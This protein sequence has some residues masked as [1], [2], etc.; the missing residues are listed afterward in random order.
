MTEPRRLRACLRQLAGRRVPGGC[1]DCDAY[2]VMTEDSG[3]FVLTVH[4]DDT[5]PTYR[6]SVR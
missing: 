6:G 1:G 5:C 4:H 2:Q 3:V